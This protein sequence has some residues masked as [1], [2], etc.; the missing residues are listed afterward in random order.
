MNNSQKSH[1]ETIHQSYVAHYGDK[2]SLIYKRRF[3]YDRILQH[4]DL[5]NKKNIE[6]ASGNGE[7]VIFLKSISKD[8]VFYGC[9]I[10]SDACEDFKRLTGFPAIEADVTLPWSGPCDFDYVFI[11]GGV[12]HCLNNLPGLFKNIEV[13]LKKGGV[14]VMIEPN[15]LFFLEPIRKLW[16]N[17]DKS[18]FAENEGALD[19]FKIID[20]NSDSF[21]LVSLT[22]VGGPAFF[23]ILQTMILRIPLWLKS[24]YSP[25]VMLVESIYEKMFHGPRMFNCFVLSIRKR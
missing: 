2:Y 16:Y 11:F 8:C 25:V 9:D 7:N 12:H 3:I 14:L 13:M 24:I 4:V 17:K 20:I 22:Y 10:S 23:L 21:D 6:L 15:A 18:M 5:N 19:P 1:F